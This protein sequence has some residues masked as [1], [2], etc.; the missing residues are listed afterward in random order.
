MFHS[1]KDPRYPTR[2]IVF[3]AF[4]QKNTLYLIS[5][6]YGKDDPRIE[7]IDITINDV[8]AQLYETGYNGR[9][10][11]RC[12]MCPIADEA[13]YIV[14]LTYKHVTST[15]T[16]YHNPITNNDIGIATL[17]KN[18]YRFIPTFYRYYKAQGVN[19]FYLYYNGHTLPSDI[20]KASDIEYVLWPYAYWNHGEGIH[21]HHAQMAAV[22]TFQYKYL[23]LCKYLILCDL[24][25]F[26]RHP[27]MK[28]STYLSS[29]GEATARCVKNYWTMLAKI[30]EDSLVLQVTDTPN[31]FFERTKTIYS[32]GFT[33]I[34]SI[35]K[36]KDC[37]DVVKDDTL[38]MCHIINVC[39]PERKH[40]IN[41]PT[42]ITVQ[43]Q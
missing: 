16:L 9:E 34:F 8:S 23:P 30:C 42:T 26:I 33:N 37:K 3:D 1:I 19:Q 21:I 14:K 43:L 22:T 32:T 15:L 31:L 13:S 24:D 11:A 40:L 18:D 4:V 36:P 35:H 17:F 2:Y 6:Y 27:T 12:F 7:D 38:M 10:P 39:H 28:L 41:N 29:A 20:F 25:E 5:T